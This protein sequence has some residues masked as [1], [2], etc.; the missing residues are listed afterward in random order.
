VTKKKTYILYIIPLSILFL[1]LNCEKEPPVTP[2]QK[3][4]SILTYERELT[5]GQEPAVSP[6]GK[7]ITYTNN[8]CIYVMDT[9]GANITQL[10]TGPTDVLPRWHPN[11]QMIGFIRSNPSVYNR[12]VLYSVPAS[13]GSETQLIINQYV[14]DSLIQV[15]RIWSNTAIPI[16]DWS[17][18]GDHVA[19]YSISGLN[20]FLNINST[21]NSSSVF[22]R[23]T[24][25][26]F[27]YSHGGR[28]FAWSSNVGKIAFIAND[29]Y[30]YGALYLFD[31]VT[32]NLMVDTTYHYPHYLSRGSITNKFIFG[33]L[34]SSVKPVIVE[35]DFS[36]IQG[37]FTTLNYCGLKWSPDEKYFLYENRRIVGGAYGYKYSCLYIYSLEKNRDYQLTTKGD[38]NQHNYFFEWGMS[39]QT[40]YFE[41][42]NKIC[43]VSFKIKS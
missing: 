38:I 42:F 4:D 14:G 28:S 5:D 39:S 18:N 3:E 19:F 31:L 9:S 32:H 24:Y 22:S 23:W 17:T 27:N 11:G 12:G 40:V 43:S 15:S 35:T 29:E 6:D 25:C 41:R 13:G 16:W 7:K 21:N 20:T 8:G 36:S 30:Q 37:E 1:Q 34:N 33:A 26:E 2:P 10:T